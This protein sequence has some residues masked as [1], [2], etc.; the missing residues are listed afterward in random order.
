MTPVT[1]LAP[2][3]TESDVS[4]PSDIVPDEK[5]LESWMHQ[6]VDFIINFGQNCFT[7][8]DAANQNCALGI[9]NPADYE[10]ITNLFVTPTS[11]V[12]GGGKT[13][14][15]TKS[16]PAKLRP[17]NVVAPMINKGIGRVLGEKFEFYANVINEDAV[18]AKLENFTDEYGDKL[19]RLIRQ[20]AQVA[21]TIGAPL[22]EGD[23]V[24]PVSIE[25][26]EAADLSTFQQEN[27]IQ[28]TNGL[29]YLMAKKSI[30]LKHKL[31]E[32][33]LRSYWT[34]GKM[35]FDTLIENDPNAIYV[36]PNNL[37]YELNSTSPFIH[38]GRYNGYTFSATPQ[39][40]VDRCPELT[41]NAFCWFR[42][43]NKSFRN[44]VKRWQILH[45]SRIL[46]TL[47]SFT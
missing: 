35:A 33:G 38:H 32:Q 29:A 19:T 28:V 7:E 30:Y 45:R 4:F 9:I 47:I 17:I 31:I 42:I 36:P 20:Q 10:H 25:D 6:W 16:L 41:K 46:R 2:E 3:P 39:S 8:R 34:T 1:K 44:T 18:S 22:V 11:T 14:G 21:E 15:F 13:N 23:D 37:I 24:Q 43:N 5:N 12:T 27:E 26:L 40:L